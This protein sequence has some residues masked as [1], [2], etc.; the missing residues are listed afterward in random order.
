MKKNTKKFI[1][2]S[3][4]AIA[5]IYVYNKLVESSAT[6]KNLL[7]TD[8]GEFYDWKEGKIYYTKKGQGSPLL[9]IHDTDSRASS[10]EWSKINKKLSK[11]HTVY[12]IDLIGCGRSDKP[13]LKYTNYMYVQLVTSF[14]KDVIG[15]QCDVVATNLSASFVIMANTLDNNLF[16]K[17]ILINPVSLSRLKAIP[18]K[19]C[20]IKQLL[21]STPLIGTFIYNRMTTPIKIDLVFRTKYFSKSQL[22]TSKIKNTYYESAHLDKSNGK[23]LLSSI[24]TNYMNLNIIHAVKRINKPIYII[25][26]RELKNNNEILETY[27]RLNKNFEIIHVS[28][29]NLYPQLEISDKIIK[30]IEKNLNK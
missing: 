18:D 26:S 7:T 20:E 4:A 22:I 13:A 12:T 14:V 21:M 16:N 10:A 2:I 30:I 28:G 25:G 5:G 29:S 15:S 27:S 3:A 11:E 9:L 1:C 17:I 24:L 6:S 23:Y 8:D 19:I